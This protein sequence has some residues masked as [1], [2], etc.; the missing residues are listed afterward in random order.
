MSAPNFSNFNYSGSFEVQEC[1]ILTHSIYEFL[2]W[3]CVS[4]G[5]YT[6]RYT[7]GFISGNISFLDTT[8]CTKSRNSW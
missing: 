4:R 8:D 5:K 1:E 2:R 3:W 6:R 7:G